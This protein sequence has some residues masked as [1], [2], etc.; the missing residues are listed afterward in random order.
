MASSRKRGFG[1]YR[2]EVLHWSIAEASLRLGISPGYLRALESGRRPW[3][4]PIAE[5]MRRIYGADLNTL[6]AWH[7]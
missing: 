4:I 5:K 7:R 3:P 1:R 6:G 2:A